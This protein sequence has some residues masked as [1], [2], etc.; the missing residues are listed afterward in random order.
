MRVL[1]PESVRNE[2]IQILREVCENEELEFLDDETYLSEFGLDSL[3]AIITIV[4]IEE[5]L[6]VEFSDEDLIVENVETLKKLMSVIHKYIS[7]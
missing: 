6:G 1:D 7:C 2:V 4:K 5:R 3:K